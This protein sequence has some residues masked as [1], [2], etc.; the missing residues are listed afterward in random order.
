MFSKGVE[1][2]NIVICLLRRRLDKDHLQIT[3]TEN[4]FG[5]L[6]IFPCMKPY[7]LQV[8]LDF[9]YKLIAS[10]CKLLQTISDRL[11]LHV[12]INFKMPNCCIHETVCTCRVWSS[13]TS[14]DAGKTVNS[15]ESQ[16]S[17]C[18]PCS[19]LWFIYSVI[20]RSFH[21]YILDFY[22]SILHGRCID[23]HI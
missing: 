18:Q 12:I 3:N 5:S 14:F 11:L 1:T 17:T 8:I 9:D 21:R 23:L 2:E 19:L 6:T 15:S 20:F 10:A 7:C 16:Q 22:F 13:F 4:I